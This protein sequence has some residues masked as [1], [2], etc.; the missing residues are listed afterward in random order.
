MCMFRAAGLLYS[1]LH[2]VQ[3]W[4]L[5]SVAGLL[6]LVS[7]GSCFTCLTALPMLRSSGSLC[8]TPDHDDVGDE[9]GGDDD[10]GDGDDL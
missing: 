6:M 8:S 2:T 5:V 1:L 10:G 3:D 4:R 7:A 9:D